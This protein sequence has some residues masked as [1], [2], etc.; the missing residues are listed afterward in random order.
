MAT[1]VG[2]LGLGSM[3]IAMARNLLHSGHQ[4][5][6]FNR[7]PG[8]RETLVREGAQGVATP[9]EVGRSGANPVFT[10]LA[11]DHAVR[12]VVAGQHGLLE[13][14]GT[15]AVH[16]GC[17]T[18]SVELAR[19]LTAVHRERDQRYLAMPVLGRPEAA[20]AGKLALLVA[21]DAASREA[22]AP[23]FSVLGART[24]VLGEE[25]VHASTTKLVCNFLIVS[26]I[27]SLGEGFRLAERS[28]VAP[29][30][31]LEILTETILNAPLVKSY[32]DIL[33]NERFSPAGFRLP[34]GLKDVRLAL[35][36]AEEV[37]TPLPVASIVRD[38]MLTAL[39]HGQDDLDWSSFVK[40]L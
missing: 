14:L 11:D 27:E 15:G 4:V 22:C 10:M 12:S 16:V 33:V 2:F 21:G 26:L 5:V 36:A 23:F 13:G 1:R 9:A 19:W 20:A 7:S 38:H 18:V 24:F 17:S 29:R 39:A 8:P 35:A 32:G 28:G 34:L 37:L 25:P 3:G 40:V 6:V 30:Q 31:V